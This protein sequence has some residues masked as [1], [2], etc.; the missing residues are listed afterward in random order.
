ME[1]KKISL[2]PLALLA[3]AFA[4]S[5]SLDEDFRNL[6]PAAAS[7]AA[8]S[9]EIGFEVKSGLGT[10]AAADAAAAAGLAQFR[11]TAFEGES[12]FYG[13]R[14]DIVTSTDNGHTWASDRL[15]YWPGDRPSDW[16]GLTFYAYTDGTG[17]DLTARASERDD[18][19]LSGYVPAI[20]DFSV[21]ADVEEQRD[22][23][24]AVAKNVSGR[25]GGKV[26]L[27]FRHAL[28]QICF[29]AQNCN[30]MI[31]DIEILD[32]ELG[33][34]CGR[35]SYRF[36][37]ASTEGGITVVLGGQEGS[38]WTLDSKAADSAYIL[39]DLDMHLGSAGPTGRGE[40]CNISV[41]SADAAKAGLRAPMLLLP[42]S[43]EPRIG[44]AA[45]GY[46]KVTVRKTLAGKA[47]PEAPQ[48]I[49][50][51][52]SADWQENRCYTYNIC[53]KTSSVNFSVNVS[54]FR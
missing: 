22:L 54:D 11:I 5:C 13:G 47:A 34:V 32:I 14:A 35:G 41:P 17:A 38:G 49:T 30:P 15:R 36:P 43:V 19:D 20:R 46:L 12:N 27:A 40:V 39:S 16:R 44:N 25:R 28:S 48:T 42:Q 50:I 53:W 33:G 6:E 26:S 1:L 23:M 29:T 31:D 18:F 7:G 10:R 9:R 37:D 51:P 52:L 45:G 24:Y 2:A 3:L 4:S 21:E 8:D